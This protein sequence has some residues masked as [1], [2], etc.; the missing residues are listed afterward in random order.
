M[1]KNILLLFLIIISTSV[2]GQTKN[3]EKKIIMDKTNYNKL[4][5]EEER[6]IIHKG[7]EYPFTGKYNNHYEEGLLC[8]QC[9]TLYISKDKFKSSWIVSFDDE[10]KGAVKR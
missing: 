4:T 8:K 1:S 3:N 2:V 5:E 6:I 10:I 7:S 9:N